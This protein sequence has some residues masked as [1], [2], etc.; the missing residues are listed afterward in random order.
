P[1]ASPPRP[2]GPRLLRPPTRLRPSPA[3]AL[4]ARRC[5]RARHRRSGTRAS[6]RPCAHSRSRVRQWTQGSVLSVRR[7]HDSGIEGKGAPMPTWALSLSLYEKKRAHPG[8]GLAFFLTDSTH[9]E[10]PPK[11]TALIAADLSPARASSAPADPRA[12]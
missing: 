9:A 2:R 5:A 11:R 3:A 12:P 7:S 8:A 6:R 4:A 1:R 10:R